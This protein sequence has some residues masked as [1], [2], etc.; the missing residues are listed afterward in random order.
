MVNRAF[1]II[2]FYLSMLFVAPAQDMSPRQAGDKLAALL[3]YIEMMYVDSTDLDILTE[4]AVKSILDELDPHSFYISAE[5]LKN[6]NE[7]LQGNFEGIGIQFQILKDTITVISAISG[8]PSEKLG[9]RSGDR[10]VSIDGKKATGKG[11][12]NQFVF[13]NLRGPKGS[14]VNVGIKRKGAVG[15]IDFTIVRD[16]I[17]ITSLDAAFMASAEIGYIKLNRFARNTVP[18]YHQAFKELKGQGLKKLIL[19]LR[20]NSGGYLYAAAELADEYLG[21]GKL[22]VYTEGLHSPRQEIES[23]W[24]GGFEKGEL[25]ILIDEGSASASEIVAGAVQDWDRGLIIGRRS[26]GKG[27]VQKQYPLTDGSAVRLT[28]AKYYT[29]SGRS[30]QKPYE[31]GSDDYLKDLSKRFE[32]GEY[33]NADSISFPDSLEFRTNMGRTVYGGGGIMPDIFVPWDSTA[34]TDVYADIVRKGI[35]S[36]F[37]LELTDVLRNEIKNNYPVVSAFIASFQP[38]DE[39]L[40]LL[41]D[42]AVKKG[43]NIDEQE[44][45]SSED[46]IKTQI[47]AL[48]ARNIYD[49]SAYFRV[50][51]KIDPTFKKAVS[52]LG[53]DELQVQLLNSEN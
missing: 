36:E 46:L 30:I 37:T 35:L 9:I 5:E 7:E 2:V 14:E 49:A 41:K 45:G 40:E 25:V 12:D 31:N 28:T 10:I 20:G 23:T 15:I 29:P 19:D 32:Q 33:V 8:G 16:E 1:L 11:I 26:F 44:W 43:L 18:E 34:Y 27:L 3:S 6:V 17:P 38:D 47:K 48:L 21:S 22:I 4:K 53:N 13:D 52:V 24:L 42:R 39:V 51:M 50:I